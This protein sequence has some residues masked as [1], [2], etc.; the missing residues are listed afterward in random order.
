M[1]CKGTFLFI[2]KN[3]FYKGGWQILRHFLNNIQPTSI[4]RRREEI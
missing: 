2:I 1:I 3:G 4:R